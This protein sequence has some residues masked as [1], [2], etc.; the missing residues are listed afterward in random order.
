MKKIL[1]VFTLIT[2]IILSAFVVAQSDVREITVTEPSERALDA[3]SEHIKAGRAIPFLGDEQGETHCTEDYV[4]TSSGD[5]EV[6]VCAFDHPLSG[7][8]ILVVAVSD[9][10]YHDAVHI[11][12]LRDDEVFHEQVS[13]AFA[14]PVALWRTLQGSGEY[15][16][17]VNIEEDGDTYSTA[18]TFTVE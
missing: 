5:S 16:V 7:L 1:A 9:D 11:V 8:D 6:V 14:E 18:F 3:S 2:M 10:G 13:D 17:L 15:E 12:V 4:A